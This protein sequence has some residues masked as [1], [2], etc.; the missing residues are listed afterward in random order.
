MPALVFKVP[1]ADFSGTGLGK[2]SLLPNIRDSLYAGYLT[3][4]IYSGNPLKDHSGNGRDLAWSGNPAAPG[5]VAYIT[6]TNGGSGYA[7]APSVSISGGG[8]NAAATAAV[9]GGVVTGVSVTNCGVG[10]SN[11]TVSFSGGGGSGAAASAVLTEIKSKSFQS[12]ARGLSALAPFSAAAVASAT[13][14]LTLV[15]FARSVDAIAH[16]PA[17][18][19]TNTGSPAAVAVT[20]NVAS[21]SAAAALCWATGM[22]TSSA[23]TLA[24]GVGRGA[25]VEIVAGAFSAT[26]GS[27]L[28]YRGRTGLATVT[29]VGTPVALTGFPGPNNIVFGGYVG[30][31]YQY[32]APEIFGALVYNR[33]L[34]AA[35]LTQVQAR[36]SALFAAY[37][38][39]L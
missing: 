8:T 21:T 25:Q 22:A 13:G 34:T 24:A 27:K 18:N 28:A 3:G 29:G 11:P 38:V 35:E 14:E 20:Q 33:A 10:Y 32:S 26:A 9:S 7:S 31:S 23:A 4:T 17:G 15:A 19:W 30:A 37:G 12:S 2:Y 16:A 5:A 36:M 39:T 6:V 1:G